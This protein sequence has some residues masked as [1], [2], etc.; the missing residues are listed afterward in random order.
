MALVI[1]EGPQLPDEERKRAM[2]KDLTEISCTY[3]GLNPWDVVVLIREEGGARMASGKGDIV[4]WDGD[5][6]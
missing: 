2:I 1:A 6:V 4:A 5:P 3:L